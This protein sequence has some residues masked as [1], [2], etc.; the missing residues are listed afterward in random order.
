MDPVAE[1]GWFTEVALVE[2]PPMKSIDDMSASREDSAGAHKGILFL[3]S[4]TTLPP[5]R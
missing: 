1:N 5:L 4:R 2:F 3:S